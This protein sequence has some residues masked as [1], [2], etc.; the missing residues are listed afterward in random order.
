MRD[1]LTQIRTANEAGIYYVALFSSL[2]I[3]DICGALES[4]D[5]LASREKYIAWFD[6]N[7]SRKH[8][9]IS[10]PVFMGNDVYLFRCSMLHQGRAQHPKSSFSRIFFIEP[11]ATTNVFH[12]CVFNDA[13]MIDVRVFVNELVEAAEHWLP[14]IEHTPQFSANLAAFV[15]RYP[16]GLV[17]FIAGVPIIG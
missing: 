4:S 3:P 16:N 1:M 15:T 6:R 10:P 11:G 12:N 17:P 2:A 5:G 14:S 7:V 9:A 8:E 13:L